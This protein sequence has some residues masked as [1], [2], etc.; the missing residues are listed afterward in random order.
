MAIPS[1][2]HILEE[3]T[4]CGDDGGG[5]GILFCGYGEGCA[6]L[7]SVIVQCLLGHSDV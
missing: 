7:V 4:A 1:G 3:R 6:E 2:S 5:A